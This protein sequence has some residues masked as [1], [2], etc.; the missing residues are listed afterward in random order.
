MPRCANLRISIHSHFLP[1]QIELEAG[2]L[3]LLRIEAVARIYD[4]APT[5]SL[6]DDMRIEIP[7]LLVIGQE[8]NRIGSVHGGFETIKFEIKIVEIKIKIGR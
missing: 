2:I 8:Q 5:H 3:P 4:G 7:E 1:E 6:A